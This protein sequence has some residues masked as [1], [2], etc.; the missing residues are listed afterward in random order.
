MTRNSD[1][2]SGAIDGAV[3]GESINGLV[4]EPIYSGVL[5]FMRRQYWSISMYWRQRK[6]PGVRVK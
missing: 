4:D 6:L 1:I 2:A 3:F 5:N